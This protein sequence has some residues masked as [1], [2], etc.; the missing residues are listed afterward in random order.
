V[1]R[2]FFRPDTLDLSTIETGMAIQRATPRDAVLVTVEF[3]QGTNSPMLLYQA[4]RRGW[5]LDLQTLS[6]HVLEY[7]R[8]KGATHFATTIF[9][10]MEAARPDVV[11]FL[12]TQHAVELRGAPGP[13]RLY[14]LR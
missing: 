7:L 14:E 4:R 12:G 3:P 11:E 5:S 1:V 2:N 13:S 10:D 9:P 6:P 8:K